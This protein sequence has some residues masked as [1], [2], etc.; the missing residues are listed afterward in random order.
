MACAVPNNHL[1]CSRQAQ[2]Q[3]QVAKQPWVKLNHA[4]KRLLL[5]LI[6]VTRSLENIQFKA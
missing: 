4:Q 2:A 3:L 6:H 1:S 5:R